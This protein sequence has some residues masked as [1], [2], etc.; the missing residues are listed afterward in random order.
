[1]PKFTLQL[2]CGLLLAL[3]SGW[4]AGAEVTREGDVEFRPAPG[5]KQAV[6]EP[7][8]MQTHSFHFE[9]KMAD[10]KNARVEM[11]EVTF[12]SPVT[13]PHP[14]NNTVHCEFFRPLGTQGP[15]PGVIVLHILGGD[16]PL[17]RLFCNHLAANGCATLFVKMPYYGPRR[18][19]NSRVRM[20][21]EDPHQ[22]V[23]GMKQAVLDI[24]RAGAWLA[25]RQEVDA[26]QLGIMG[27]SLGGIVSA[28]A[29]E[30]E[31][32]FKKVG[33]LLAG[34][35]ISKVAWESPELRKVRARWQAAGGTRESLVEVVKPIDPVTYA[36]NLRNRKVLMLNA[37]H[38]EIIPKACTEALW[39]AAGEPEI[40]WWNAGHISSA[41]YILVGLDR[42][43]KLFGPEKES[44]PDQ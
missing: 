19:P 5:E 15:V 26:E 22:T 20:V 37:S 17:A 36:A 18:D 33:L 21:S 6:P 31:P 25:S 32:R 43:T 1:M 8:R 3:A 40:E 2:T 42:V 14:R 27:I 23:A 44:L 4:C 28:L 30:C 11:S 12:P 38:D 16:F 13:T 35:D 9:Q 7:F 29:A 34:G 39:R 41:R 10:L 24:R